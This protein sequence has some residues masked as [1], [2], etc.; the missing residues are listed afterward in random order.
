[1][2]PKPRLSICQPFDKTGLVIHTERRNRVPRGNIYA[3]CSLAAKNN[4]GFR[5]DQS[6]A[7]CPVW[8]VGSHGV[9]WLQVILE[10]G[11]LSPRPD[12]A[13]LGGSLLLRSGL[14]TWVPSTTALRLTLL[15]CTHELP[16]AT[17]GGW[18]GKMHSFLSDAWQE[19]A[20]SPL[21]CD[22][23]RWSYPKP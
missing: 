17:T 12:K 13:L 3:S 11:C 19:G 9:S 22:K 6:G 21:H 18:G 14:R 10:S 20:E 4:L 5:Q 23:L 1:M 16:G 8:A 7:F 2:T 15:T